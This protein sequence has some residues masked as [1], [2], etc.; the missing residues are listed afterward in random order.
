A[1]A[2]CQ[3]KLVVILGSVTP[4]GR[5]LSATG[6]LLDRELAAHKEVNVELINLADKRIAFADGRPPEE[7]QDDT[8]AVVQSV[9]ACDGVIIAS[10]VYRGSITG[11]L[12]NL[13]DHLPV[14]SLA[15]K[16][17]GI[18]AM[19]ATHHHYLGVDWHLRD[20]LAWF[21]AMV[22]PTSVYL[23]SGD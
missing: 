11:A 14:E 21:G 7:Y 2:R 17:V 16:P 6:W 3:M 23:A 4:P 15:A 22:L 1:E 8:A 18:V 10:P 13:L 12:K 20:I 5:L 19:G 9:K